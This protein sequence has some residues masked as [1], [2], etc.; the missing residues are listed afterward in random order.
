LNNRL[1]ILDVWVDPVGREEAIARVRGFLR[2]GNRPHSIFASNPEKNF[3]VPRDPELYNCYRQAD[4]LLPDGIGMVKAAKVLHG[5]RLS[6]VPGSEFIFDICKVAQEEDCGVFVYGAKEEVNAR[7]CEVLAERFPGLK[8]A[9]RANGYVKEVDM[10]GLVEQIND[11]GAA[12]LFVALG[13]PKQE[14]WFAKYKAHL[15]NVRVVQGIG[16]TLDTIGG[17]VKRAPEFWCRHNIEWLYRLVSEPK[18]IARQRVLPVFVWLVFVEWMKKRINPLVLRETLKNLSPIPVRKTLRAGYKVFREVSNRLDCLRSRTVSKK[19]VVE[20]LHRL[21][22]VEGDIVLVHSSLSRLGYVEGGAATVVAALLETVGPKGTVGAPT[23]WG[24]SRFYIKG[25]TIYDVIDSQSLLGAVSEVI[26]KHPGAKR[27]LHPTH[28]AAFIGPASEFLLGEHHRDM[29][30]VGPKS[31]YRKLVDLRGKIVLLGVSL[32]CVTNFHTI[33]DEISDFPIPVYC[34]QPIKFKVIDED[35]RTK[36]VVTYCH[37]PET[38]KI[39]RF[40]KMGAPLSRLQVLKATNLGKSKAMAMDAYQL[41]HAL[42]DLFKGGETIY[43][44]KS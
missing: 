31:P 22:V 19:D 20:A 7:S 6:R 37:D 39:R 27:S 15:K 5:A 30:P 17:T 44:I 34:R 21:G 10:S 14:K 9:G 4:L 32:E 24:Y 13:S 29:T 42:H 36:E 26:R 16:G 28:P 38:E 33:E 23:F 12:V 18:R 8:I 25:K 40:N 3:S 41:H 43:A 11:S 35:R 2:N 1:A